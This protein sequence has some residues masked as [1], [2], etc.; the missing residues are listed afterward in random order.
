MKVEGSSYCSSSVHQKTL[1]KHLKSTTMI[2]AKIPNIHK[3][4]S[5]SSATPSKDLLMTDTPT[6]MRSESCD[7]KPNPPTPLALQCASKQNNDK[8]RASSFGL[9]CHNRSLSSASR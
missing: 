7:E 5:T 3:S 1:S 8:N 4:H 9:N 6:Y 2:H